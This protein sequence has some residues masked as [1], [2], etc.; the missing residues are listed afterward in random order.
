M[1][2]SA[3]G[4]L[5]FSAKRS[6]PSQLEPAYDP[7]HPSSTFLRLEF[8]SELMFHTYCDPPAWMAYWRTSLLCPAAFLAVRPTLTVPFFT[9]VTVGFCSLLVS[10]SAYWNTQFHSVGLPVE[11]SRK[12]TGTSVGT[13]T[14]T[15]GLSYP[16]SGRPIRA[17]GAFWATTTKPLR[18]ITSLS[19]PR[20]TV[21]LTS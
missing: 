18:S 13:N 3:S 11:R 12:V 20:R 4:A 21:R 7:N 17:V 9:K 2:A 8:S 19:S 15:Q 6:S 14:P 1:V 10:L 5:Y 16:S